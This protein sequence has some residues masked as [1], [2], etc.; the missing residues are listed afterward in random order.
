MSISYVIKKE[1]ES[2]KTELTAIIAKAIKKDYVQTSWNNN[3]LIIKIKKVATS[4]ICIELKDDNGNV[5]IC[6]VK[7]KIAMMHKPFV[8][9]VEKIVDDIL[10]N[11]LGAK[12]A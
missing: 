6:E 3:E 2:V 12:R 10:G 7:R 11:K 1:I 8:G 9:E 5:H 4:E